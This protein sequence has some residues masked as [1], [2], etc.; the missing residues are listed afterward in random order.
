[1]RSDARTCR[2]DPYLLPGRILTTKNRRP[3][4]PGPRY[5]SPARGKT[6]GI[7]SMRAPLS[8]RATILPVCGPDSKVVFRGHCLQKTFHI[9]NP[10]ETGFRQ[11]NGHDKC[12]GRLPPVR[13]RVPIDLP[14]GFQRSRT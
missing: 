14:N 13:H 10:S 3:E 7:Q 9:R 5:V 6:H 4:T 1:M 12:R 11:P 2:G 8:V